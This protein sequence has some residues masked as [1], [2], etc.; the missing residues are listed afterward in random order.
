MKNTRKCEFRYIHFTST[1]HAKIPSTFRSIKV[2]LSYIPTFTSIPPTTM[3]LRKLSRS[4]DG[5][6]SPTRVP[7]TIRTVALATSLCSNITLDDIIFASVPIHRGP[8]TTFYSR[9]LSPISS[10]PSTLRKVAT[11][12]HWRKA[13]RKSRMSGGSSSA[14]KRY[15]RIE[16]EDIRSSRGLSQSEHGSKAAFRRMELGGSP[17]RDLPPK[18]NN[19]QRRGTEPLPMAVR[20]ACLQDLGFL[21]DVPRIALGAVKR[22]S[23]SCQEECDN[24]PPS[25]PAFER[26]ASDGTCSSSMPLKMPV[27]KASMDE[28]RLKCCPCSQALQQPMRQ[29]SEDMIPVVIRYASKE[30]MD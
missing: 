2:G 22:F 29:P 12:E 30:S 10:P 7:G 5:L 6:L 14:V 26:G 21:E 20:K 25:M 1:A 4:G 28:L 24:V 19:L 3:H 13:E 8:E 18:R 23:S 11:E 9:S 16:K 17:Y 15:H 27:R